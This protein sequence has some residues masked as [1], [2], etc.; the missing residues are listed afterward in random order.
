MSGSAHMCKDAYRASHTAT[1]PA[2]YNA[3]VVVISIPLQIQNTSEELFLARPSVHSQAE[4]LH[5]SLSLCLC[6]FFFFDFLWE[7]E[8]LE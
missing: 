2:G 4:R 1:D 5:T 3:V 8:P 6:F 7:T